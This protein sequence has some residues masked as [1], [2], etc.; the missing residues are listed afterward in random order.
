VDTFTTTQILAG[1]MGLY[2]V[3]AGINLLTNSEATLGMIKDMIGQ[4]VFGFLGGLVAFTVG[5]VIVAIHHDWSS[6]LAGFITL[7][8]WIAL[9]EGVLLIACGKWFLGLFARLK[10]TAG[11]IKMF[12]AGTL[13][14][15]V[16]MIWAG[17]VA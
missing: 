9:A 12:G 7:I 14:L 6:L 4:P 1:L 10:F 8:G 17:L 16:V 15:G 5:G 2:F 13:T 11:I 3:A